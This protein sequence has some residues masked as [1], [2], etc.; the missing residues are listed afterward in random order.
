MSLHH[1]ARV[2]SFIDADIVVCWNGRCG[3]AGRCRTL[4]RRRAS[5]ILRK[6]QGS[7]AHVFGDEDGLLALTESQ[8]ADLLI[9]WQWIRNRIWRLAALHGLTG[10]VSEGREGEG[11]GEDWGERPELTPA[12]VLDVAATAVAIC[13]RLSL[14]AMEA[15]GVGFVEKLYDI[16][17]TV[18]EL[19][20]ADVEGGGGALAIRSERGQCTQMLQSL[21]SFVARHRAGA[22]FAV[23]LSQAVTVANALRVLSSGI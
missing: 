5:R 16:A 23:P 7:A 10:P 3:G 22:P 18:A 20:Q 13:R 14:A 4:T 12:Y 9:T 6:L 1:L 15:H 8:K 17:S 19:V 21:S 11:G 2:F